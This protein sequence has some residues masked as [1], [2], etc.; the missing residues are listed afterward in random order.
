MP[1]LSAIA[2]WFLG[3]PDQALRRSQEAVTLAQELSHPLSLSAAY[4]FKGF[5]HLFRREGRPSLEQA[6][7]AM[8]IAADQ[9]FVFFIAF[10]TI[11]RGWALAEKGESEEG[12]SQMLQGLDAYRATGAEALLPQWMAILADSYGQLGQVQEGID[13][14]ADAQILADK[15]NGERWFIA[16][17]L[18]I[19]GKLLMLGIKDKLRDTA[20]YD[21]AETCF[22]QA[23]KLAQQQ[24]AKSLELRAAISLSRLWQRQ[25]KKADA[26]GLLSKIYNWFEE[27]FDTPDLKAAKVLLEELGGFNRF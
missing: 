8:A 2:H 6:E 26:Y 16:E 12:F 10:D 11:L 4:H 20:V 23:I 24:E 15:N 17:T 19:K 3:Y 25:D 21:E 27:G 13:I 9:G 14:L 1:A 22:L 7:A 5:L 18:R